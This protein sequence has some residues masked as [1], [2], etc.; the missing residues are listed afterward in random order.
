MIIYQNRG[1]GEYMSR[2]HTEID[3]ERGRRFKSLIVKSGRAQYSIAEQLGYQP[4]HI[5]NII[6]GKRRLMPDLAQ[7]IVE[8]IFPNVNIDWL[9]NRSECETIEEKEKISRKIWEEN[10]KAEML[11]DKAFRFF[12]DGIEDICGYGL[13]SQGTDLLIGDYIVVSDSTGEKVGVIRAESFNKLREEIENFASYSINRLIKQEMMAIPKSE[14][15]G[16]ENG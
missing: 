6:C 14:M 5:S 16:E 8:E 15:D 9:L 3:P 7:R 4:Q 1:N 2:K 12:I 11:Y 13:H 10:H